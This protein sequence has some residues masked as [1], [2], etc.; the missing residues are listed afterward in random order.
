MRGSAQCAM[1]RIGRTGPDER[2]LDPK[3]RLDVSDPSL[4]LFSLLSYPTTITSN[5][6][7]AQA[8][9]GAVSV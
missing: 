4:S 6:T 7:A 3:R 9:Q 1:A 2:R 8:I 5:T